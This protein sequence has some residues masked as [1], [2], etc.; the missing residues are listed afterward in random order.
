MLG[1]SSE[2]CFI[3]SLWFLIWVETNLHGWLVEFLCHECL[4]IAVKPPVSF[5]FAHSD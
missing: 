3:L 4:L 2:L 1:I 5:V